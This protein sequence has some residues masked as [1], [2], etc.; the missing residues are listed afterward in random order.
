MKIPKHKK[1]DRKEEAKR[2]RRKYGMQSICPNCKEDNEDGG[3]YVPPSLGEKGR[4]ICKA[5][6]PPNE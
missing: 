6:A 1:E 3:H 4:W 5:A 2:L